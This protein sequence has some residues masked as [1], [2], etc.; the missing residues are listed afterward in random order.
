[1]VQPK[2]GRWFS[3]SPG[4]WYGINLVDGTVLALVDGTVLAIGRWYSPSPGRWYSPS[5]LCVGVVVAAAEAEIGG[6]TCGAG[7]QQSQTPSSGQLEHP[8]GLMHSF[9][10]PFK[11][12]FKQYT[13]WVAV[14]IEN[15]GN[16]PFWW[17]TLLQCG[18]C[19]LY[20]MFYHENHSLLI[21]DF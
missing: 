6:S 15:Q 7:L 12:P 11:S 19:P 1:M 2:P 9:H 4:R 5:S 18:V 3:R 21:L 13:A 10:R 16:V 20:Q 8:R 14:V 17:G